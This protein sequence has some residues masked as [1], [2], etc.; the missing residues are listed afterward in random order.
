[1]GKPAAELLVQQQRSQTDGDPQKGKGQADLAAEIQGQMPVIPDRVTAVGN[2]TGQKLH[3]R[4]DPCSCYGP[5]KQRQSG[6]N[7][8]QA[9]QQQ[10]AGA[11][12]KEHGHMAPAP[13]KKL[14]Q[15]ISQTAQAKKQETSQN[16]HSISLRKEPAQKIPEKYE[17]FA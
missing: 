11:P 4:D 2:E 13:P 8:V 17:Y 3:H 14:Q 6:A 9:A 16:F 1:M 12:G 15:N 10:K 7:G 5:E